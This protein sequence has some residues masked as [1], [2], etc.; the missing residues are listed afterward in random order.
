[1]TKEFRGITIFKTRKVAYPWLAGMMLARR[2]VAA[3]NS[4]Q[5]KTD[6]ADA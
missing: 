1:M 6:Q 2:L 3:G 4:E 5:K